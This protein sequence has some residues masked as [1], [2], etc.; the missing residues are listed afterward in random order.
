M[1]NPAPR[2]GDRFAQTD[3]LP[4][5]LE[6]IARSDQRDYFLLSL[7][8]R[9]AALNVQAMAARPRSIRRGLAHRHDQN[10]TPQNVPL[11]PRGPASWS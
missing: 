8:T 9:R 10:G 11:S 5:L 3:E 1:K 7:L 6:T 4:R 2:R